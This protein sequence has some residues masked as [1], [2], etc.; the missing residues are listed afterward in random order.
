MGGVGRVVDA[1]ADVGAHVGCF[2]EVEDHEKMAGLACGLRRSG[3]GLLVRVLA[4]AKCHHPADNAIREE[5]HRDVGLSVDAD[6][7]AQMVLDGGGILRGRDATR[8]R[9]DAR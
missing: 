8:R 7:V 4:V 6:R 9:D 3:P 1:A 5:V 2:L